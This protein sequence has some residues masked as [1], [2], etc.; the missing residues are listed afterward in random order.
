MSE[1]DKDIDIEL[2]EAKE[3]FQIAEKKA[4]KWIENANE[5]IEAMNDKNKIRRNIISQVNY[6]FA[7]IRGF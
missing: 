7:G 3:D 6:G 2:S 4:K 5:L 1:K